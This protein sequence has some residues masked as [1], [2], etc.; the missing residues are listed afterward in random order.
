[1][2]NFL[3]KSSNFFYRHLVFILFIKLNVHQK[4]LKYIFDL[5]LLFFANVQFLKN[6]FL[7]FFRA[8]QW[9]SNYFCKVHPSVWLCLQNF[10]S[11]LHLRPEKTQFL[12]SFHFPYPKCNMWKD[13]LTHKKVKK[14]E[15]EE[16]TQRER[17]GRNKIKTILRR[18]NEGGGG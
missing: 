15:R 12:L 5:S 18:R 4:V 9:H 14:K 3:N 11:F 2:P 10:F 17:E 8:H 1:M 16:E 13:R 6:V 7:S